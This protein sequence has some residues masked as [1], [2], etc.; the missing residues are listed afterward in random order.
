[1]DAYRRAT[2]SLLRQRTSPLHWKERS[3]PI[4]E[5]DQDAPKRGYVDLNRNACRRYFTGMII[6]YPLGVT[7][8]TNRLC[9][10]VL[11]VLVAQCTYAGLSA[12]EYALTVTPGFMGIDGLPNSRIPPVRSS[13]YASSCSGW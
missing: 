13:K 5:C 7:T 1:M 4:V 12:G 10:L 11:L 9:M 6:G 8:V 2:A 3:S